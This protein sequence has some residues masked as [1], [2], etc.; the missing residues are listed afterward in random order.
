MLSRI[1][2]LP[3][4]SCL[5]TPELGIYI[6][7][8]TFFTT[9][10]SHGGQETQETDVEHYVRR[11]NWT[12]KKQLNCPTWLGTTRALACLLR[13]VIKMQ[14]EPGKLANCAGPEIPFPPCLVTSGTNP[15][16]CCAWSSLIVE[17]PT[18]QGYAGL[19]CALPSIARQGCSSPAF[20]WILCYVNYQ[21]LLGAKY[22]AQVNI[23]QHSA[24]LRSCRQCSGTE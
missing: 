9:I 14:G 24:A 13:V 15:S 6:E 20:V 8:R 22:W 21:A 17:F 16:A 19:V 4:P 18:K 11:K 3:A 1:Q 2:R 7:G 12:D 5:H 23:S 10:S